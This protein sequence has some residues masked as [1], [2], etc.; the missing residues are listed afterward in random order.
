MAI[1]AL[2]IGSFLVELPSWSLANPARSAGSFSVGRDFAYASVARATLLACDGD[3]D[4]DQYA[5]Q[6]KKIKEKKK[7]IKATAGLASLN[8]FLSSSVTGDCL[9]L[10]VIGG[11]GRS[12]Q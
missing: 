2:L 4:I 6:D 5:M 10:A 12:L 9:V 3:M 11:A 1:A 8:V 7:L